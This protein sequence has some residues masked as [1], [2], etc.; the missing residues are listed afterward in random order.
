MKEAV[1]WHPRSTGLGWLLG[2]CRV[3]GSKG[4]GCFPDLTIGQFYHA[5][6]HNCFTVGNFPTLVIAGMVWLPAFLLSISLIKQN[7]GP[8]SLKQTHTALAL[9]PRKN[10]PVTLPLTQTLLLQPSPSFTCHQTRSDMWL[11]Q[12]RARR[13]RTVVKEEHEMSSLTQ[14]SEVMD[15]SMGNVMLRGQSCCWS[16]RDCQRG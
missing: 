5:V 13:G 12:R 1:C 15:L 9:P 14:S 2:D 16:H 3:S 6:T 7:K 10:W 11:A 4:Q 8:L